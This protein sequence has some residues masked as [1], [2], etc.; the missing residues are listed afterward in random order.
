MED[1]TE[2][3]ILARFDKHEEF[4]ELQN[5]ILSLDITVE[6]SEEEKRNEALLVQKLSNIVSIGF[7]VHLTREL[8]Y[9]C[10]S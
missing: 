7:G 6:P 8:L 9:I 1:P 2:G 5:Q 4:T 3:R 10:Y